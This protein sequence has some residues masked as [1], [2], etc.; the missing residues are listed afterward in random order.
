MRHKS[1]LI[2]KSVLICALLLTVYVASAQTGALPSIYSLLLDDEQPP[3]PEISNRVARVERTNQTTCWDNN[4]LEINCAGT[5]QDGELQAGVPW[6]EPRFVDNGDGTVVDELTGLVWLKDGS[7]LTTQMDFIIGNGI[8]GL[9]DGS[10]Q[11]DWHMPNIRELFSLVDVGSQGAGLPVGHPFTLSNPSSSSTTA[12][13][14]TTY[15]VPVSEN[16]AFSH[17]GVDFDS[18]SL[19]NGNIATS[20]FDNGLNGTFFVLPVR[21]RNPATGELHLAEGN[22][23]ARVEATGQ[24]TCGVTFG[25]FKC[26]ASDEDGSGQWGMEFPTPRFVDNRDGT[27]TD[28]LTGLV[29]MI[30]FECADLTGLDWQSVLTA[31]RSFASG[32]CGVSDDS[33]AGDWRVP[34]ALELL[35][36]HSVPRRSHQ[37]ALFGQDIN[38]FWSSTSLPADPTKAFISRG[39]PLVAQSKIIDFFDTIIVRDPGN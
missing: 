18:P 20:I 3:E 25:W 1:N 4:G 15:Y 17:A 36:L 30:D 5:G 12:Y 38:T 19:F 6:P 37:H 39:S 35:S 2:N 9:S 29:W 21:H 22:A 28:R 34:N 10:V 32:Q 14:S 16:F 33:S 27:V 8:C 13:F 24:M 31:A 23:P 7:C 26:G 11:D